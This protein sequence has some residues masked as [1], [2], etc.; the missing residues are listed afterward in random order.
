MEIGNSALQESDQKRMMRRYP[1][2]SFFLCKTVGSKTL[3]SRPTLFIWHFKKSPKL[4]E[5]GLLERIIISEMK[6]VI[7]SGIGSIF[8][9]WFPRW[10][11]FNLTLGNYWKSKPQ[12]FGNYL[13][14]ILNIATCWLMPEL[15]AGKKM[16]QVWLL[17][18]FCPISIPKEL[19]FRLQPWRK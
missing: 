16:M 6:V 17:N 19:L 18:F 10:I 2:L 7:L 13:E 14:G 5:G 4:A 3:S 8:H 9:L 1:N 12:Q 11:S 15:F